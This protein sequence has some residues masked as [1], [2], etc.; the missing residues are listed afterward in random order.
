[1]FPIRSPG[2]KGL[3][4]RLVGEEEDP[5]PWPSPHCVGRGDLEKASLVGRRGARGLGK[6]F[7]RRPA[8]G[9]GSKRLQEMP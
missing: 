7:T 8:W 2:P 5:S 4:Q 3:R 1:M 9:E 6:S